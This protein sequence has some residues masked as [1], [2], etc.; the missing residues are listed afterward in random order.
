MLNVS[1]FPA[2]IATEKTETFSLKQ[3]N[4]SFQ[5]SILKKSIIIMAIPYSQSFSRVLKQFI[6]YNVVLYA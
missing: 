1:V 4:C 5:T 3:Y 6:D 2:A